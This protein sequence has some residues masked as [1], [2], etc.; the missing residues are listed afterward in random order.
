MRSATS[1]FNGSLYRKTLARFWPLWGLWGVIWLFALPLSLLGN[2]F[3][4]DMGSAPQERLLDMAVY[5]PQ[6]LMP[7]LL[8]VFGFAALCAM[9]VFGYLYNSRS[10]CWT[11]ALPLR[12]EALFTT[13]YLAGLS[14]LLLPHLAACLLA[15][16]V[17]LSFLPVEAWSEVLPPLLALALA[18]SG[19]SLFFFSFASFCAMF[20]G[21]ILALPAF[22]VILNCLAYGLWFLIDGLIS[23]FYYGYDGISGMAAVVELL[24]PFAALREAAGWYPPHRGY[25][26]YLQSPGG[27]AAYAAVGVGLALVSLYVYRRRHVETA[28]DVVAVALVR[29]LFKYGVAFCSGLA[30]GMFTNAFFGWGGPAM[31]ALCILLW[32]VTGYFAAEMLLRKSFRVLKAWKGG[33]AMAGVMLVLCLVCFLDPFGVVKRVPDP[34]QVEFVMV[35]INMGY[36][37]DSGHSLDAYLD[38]SD[39]IQIIT[40]L[41]QAIVDNRDGERLGGS[42]QYGYT[43][44]LLTYRLSNGKELKRNYRSVPLSAGDLDTPGTTAYAMRQLTENQE[45]VAKAYNFEGFLKGGRITS[46]WLDSLKDKSG[47]YSYV[48]LDDYRQELWDA[49]LQDFEEGTLG[50]HG[51][52]EENYSK[53]YETD[54]VFEVAET[55]DYAGVELPAHEASAEVYPSSASKRLRITLTPNARHTLEVLNQSGVWE[56]GYTFAGQM[57]DSSQPSTSVE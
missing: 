50:V 24:T 6:W 4:R 52:F 5:L 55:Q 48:Y 39:Q 34:G 22:Y 16:M 31:L 19:I 32:T 21:H 40:A 53:F 26:G 15:G 1:Y 23:T 54:L 2:Y 12:R 25:S 7:G 11:H 3:A 28:G 56:R 44:A 47:E 29:P 38:G 27:I 8:L 17:E 43:S 45:L 37:Y 36:P 51:F 57:A 49:M 10:A 30:F 13:Q 14:M 41:H 46:A 35:D 20:T 9:A 18:Q 33:A 42:S